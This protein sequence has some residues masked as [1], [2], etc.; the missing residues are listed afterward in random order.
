MMASESDKRVGIM[1]RKT[2]SAVARKAFSSLHHRSI[3]GVGART[4]RDARKSHDPALSRP[5]SANV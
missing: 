2:E 1:N 5:P 3:P 4:F